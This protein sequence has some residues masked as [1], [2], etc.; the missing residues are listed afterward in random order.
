MFNAELLFILVFDLSK[1]SNTAYTTLYLLPTVYTD[2]FSSKAKP[3]TVAINAAFGVQLCNH[4]AIDVP[5]CSAVCLLVTR[6]GCVQTV[7]PIA[8]RFGGMVRIGPG[9]FVRAW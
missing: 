9:H 4:I 2:P 5:R 6:V 3:L 1:F 7:D 8:M